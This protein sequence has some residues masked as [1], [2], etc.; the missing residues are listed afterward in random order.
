MMA[1]QITVS[2]GDRLHIVI[3]GLDELPSE[4]RA[5]FL[6]YLNK[7]MTANSGT[8]NNTPATADA[9]SV[10]IASQPLADIKKSLMAK[11][12][13]SLPMA[14][15]AIGERVSVTLKKFSICR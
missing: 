7:L 3:D 8:K 5:R 10:Y 14:Q 12:K 6:K 15:V 2:T 4:E 9:V 11:R 13:G 1:I